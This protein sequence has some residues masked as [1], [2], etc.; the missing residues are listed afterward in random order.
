[1]KCPNEPETING[2]QDQ[3]GCPD[4]GPPP[5]AKIEKGQIVILE[6]SS[7]IPTSPPSSR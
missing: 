1:M 4:K 6:R 3:D 7:S 2:Y 5:K